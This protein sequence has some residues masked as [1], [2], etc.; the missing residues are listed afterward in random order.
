MLG[1]YGYITNTCWG[2]EQAWKTGLDS[3]Y[4]PSNLDLLKPVLGEHNGPQWYLTLCP[5]WTWNWA[6]SHVMACR[7]TSIVVDMS[8]LLG[9][10]HNS[11]YLKCYRAKTVEIRISGWGLRTELSLNAF[12]LGE[13]KAD[14]MCY[15]QWACFAIYILQTPFPEGGG[16]RETRMNMWNRVVGQASIHL[17]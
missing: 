13:R 16:G 3:E 12:F 2:K 9:G 5:P 14:S 7:F 4:P 8:G 11:V 6:M 17:H 1:T 15:F 10:S